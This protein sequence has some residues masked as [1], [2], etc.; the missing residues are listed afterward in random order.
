MGCYSGKTKTK[1]ESTKPIERPPNVFSPTIETSKR[2]VERNPNKHKAPLADARV[3]AGISETEGKNAEIINRPK[4][5]KE[6]E[7]ISKSLSGHFLFNS[8]SE[9]NLKSVIDKI[10]LYILGPKEIVF[11][12]GSPAQN[13]YI[14][15]SGRVEVI[16]N[17]K[18]KKFA[19]KGEQFG[20]LALLH[21]S[22]RTATISTIDKTSLWAL[23]REGFQDAIQSIC[24]KKYSENKQFI[25]SIPIFNS[26][27]NNQKE[28]LLS[29]IVTHEFNDG[30]KIVVEGDPGNLLYII[31]TGSVLCT[32][33]SQEIRKLW[34]GEFFGEQALLYNTQRTATVIAIGKVTVLSLGRDDL[35]TAFGTHLQQIIYRNSQRISIEKSK[36][37][38]ILTKSQIE[39]IID[40][41]E[42]GSYKPG[43]IVIGRGSPKGMKIYIILKGNIK[44]GNKFFGLYSCIGDEEIQSNATDNWEDN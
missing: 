2:E 41:M 44:C 40:R 35:T 17:G 42:I 13:F 8:I 43:Q 36:V 14:I 1:L 29:M 31:K 26:F 20:E 7:E 5:L 23:S 21:D 4:S 33:G 18:T 24:N 6:Y 27:N 38:K 19:G 39:A 3:K 32:K 15:A 22:L 16:V 37:L 34:P 30:N 11:T 12:Q 28:I 10:K 9:E 25:E